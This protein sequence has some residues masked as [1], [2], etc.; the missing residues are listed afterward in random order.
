MTT[1][2]ILEYLAS[3]SEPG[4]TLGDLAVSVGSNVRRLI[5]YAAAYSKVHGMIGRCRDAGT[6]AQPDLLGSCNYRI[7]LPGLV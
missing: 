2:Y 5:L 4:A 6:R 7:P 3:P 1:K